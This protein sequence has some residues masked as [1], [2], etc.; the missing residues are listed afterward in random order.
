MLPGPAVSLL[1]NRGRGNVPS[2]PYWGGVQITDGPG[3]IKFSFLR[4]EN[5]SSDITLQ[6]FSS[7]LVFL[8]RRPSRRASPGFLYRAWGTQPPHSLSFFFSLLMRLCARKEEPER[9]TLFICIYL[10]CFWAATVIKSRRLGWAM[11]TTLL[12][13]SRALCADFPPPSSP[14]QHPAWPHELMSKWHLEI[15]NP[16]AD[17]R[18]DVENRYAEIAEGRDKDRWIKWWHR[19]RRWKWWHWEHL[20]WEVKALSSPDRQWRKGAGCLL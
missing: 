5:D 6:L 9:A 3:K 20:K 10:L 13:F 2:G 16:A 1:S 7:I 15:T 12:Y 8:G 14:R 19:G 4:G 17:H 18:E 11:R